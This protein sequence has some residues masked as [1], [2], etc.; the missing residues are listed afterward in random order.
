VSTATAP[1]ADC[2]EPA[3]TETA[4]YGSLR[5]HPGAEAAAERKLGKD[6]RLEKIPARHAEEE[7][8]GAW[9]GAAAGAAAIGIE[10]PSRRESWR[11]LLTRESWL[12]EALFSC[13]VLPQIPLCKK[14][15]LRH[16]KMSANVWNTKCWWNQK[17]IAQ[18]CCTLRD[19]HFKPS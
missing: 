10:P 7:D 13:P 16:I 11:D 1:G 8:T 12:H 19:E 15:I 14:K 5:R 2:A 17:L 4:G 3:T 9:V 6:V 18:F